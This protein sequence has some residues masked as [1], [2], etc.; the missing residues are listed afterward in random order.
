MTYEII[1]TNRFKK[2]RLRL[3]GEVIL[4]VDEVV[5]RLANGESLEAKFKDHRLKG[6]LSG[7]REC[8]VK[9]DILLLY[10]LNK[11]KL[12]LTCLRVGSHAEIF[13]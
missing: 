13:G 4:L 3:S 7:V 8:H 6:D 10:E 9:P 1:A 11:N 12:I 2:E 5:F